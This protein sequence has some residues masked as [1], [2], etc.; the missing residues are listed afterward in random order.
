[1]DKQR[2]KIICLEMIDKLRAMVIELDKE[3]PYPGYLD[4]K[5]KPVE[6]DVVCVREEINL[7]LKE[8]TM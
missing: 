5:L 8:N 2:T 6:N 7:C 3:N 4:E 1:M